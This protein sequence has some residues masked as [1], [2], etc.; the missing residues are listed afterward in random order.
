MPIDRKSQGFDTSPKLE[1]VDVRDTKML[2]TEARE[3]ASVQ[4]G[5]SNLKKDFHK[6][7][8]FGKLGSRG[9]GGN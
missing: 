9:Y 6:Q 4:S 8:S 5:E 3:P 1:G 2:S 7:K